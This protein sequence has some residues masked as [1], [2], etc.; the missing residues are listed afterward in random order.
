MQFVENLY[1]NSS[2]QR[3][4]QKANNYMRDIQGV[5]LQD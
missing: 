4:F 3:E 1:L 2:I 5:L